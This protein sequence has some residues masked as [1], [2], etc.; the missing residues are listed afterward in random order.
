VLADADVILF[1]SERTRTPKF[2]IPWL[3]NIVC[4]VVGLLAAGRIVHVQTLNQIGLLVG[5]LWLILYA[6]EQSFGLYVL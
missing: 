4:S 6:V 1:G 3:A 2:D 5:A